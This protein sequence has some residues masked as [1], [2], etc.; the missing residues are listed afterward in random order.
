LENILIHKDKKIFI[1][2]YST[3]S[4]SSFGITKSV[5]LAFSRMIPCWT[6]YYKAIGF[7]TP[8][9]FV[10]V[11]VPVAAVLFAVVVAVVVYLHIK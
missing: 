1:I 4:D 6:Q 7:G 5:I 9:L 3:K 10:I 2:N 11:V 8:K